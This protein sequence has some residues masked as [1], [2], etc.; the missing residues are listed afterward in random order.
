MAIDPD[1]VA[2]ME[3]AEDYAWRLD[4][5]VM[6][7]VRNS[8]HS[9]LRSLAL[10]WLRKNKPIVYRILKRKAMDKYPVSNG[11]GTSQ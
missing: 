5:E 9:Y 1:V 3:V 8:R 11:T 4:E 6:I 10:Q 2:A 7:A